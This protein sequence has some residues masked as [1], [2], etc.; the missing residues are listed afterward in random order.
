[1]QVGLIKANHY[2]DSAACRG[3]NKV[4]DIDPAA[5]CFLAA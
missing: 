4:N 2:L 1:M 5:S 3:E